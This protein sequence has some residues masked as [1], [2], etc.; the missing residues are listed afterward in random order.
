LEVGTQIKERNIM[1][2]IEKLKIR[3]KLNDTLKRG[4]SDKKSESE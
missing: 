4:L 3:S 2:R 1:D